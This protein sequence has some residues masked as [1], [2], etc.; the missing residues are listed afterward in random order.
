M[1]ICF[2]VC[3]F[4]EERLRN[5]SIKRSRMELKKTQTSKN[6]L[7]NVQVLREKG[8]RENWK[9]IWMNMKE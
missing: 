8:N 3:F 6:F 7:H 1:S 9:E 5:G 2:D 4:K